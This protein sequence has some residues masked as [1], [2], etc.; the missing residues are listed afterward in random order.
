MSILESLPVIGTYFLFLTFEIEYGSGF[1][2]CDFTW[3]PMQD[4]I[5]GS[6]F[7]PYRYFRWEYSGEERQTRHDGWMVMIKSGATSTWWFLYEISLGPW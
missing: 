6:R 5:H 4:T 1:A 3:I 2:G 7:I